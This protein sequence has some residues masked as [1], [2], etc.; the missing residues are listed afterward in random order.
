MIPAAAADALLA[1]MLMDI[2]SSLGRPIRLLLGLPIIVAGFAVA[3]RAMWR[4]DDTR[5]VA[6]L[7]QTGC[8]LFVMAAVGL[9]TPSLHGAL[10]YEAG[11]RVFSLLALVAVGVSA[12]PASTSARG[13]SACW[14]TKARSP[15]PWRP[16]S[17]SWP[18]PTRARP[19]G[20][21]SRRRPGACPEATDSRSSNA[22]TERARFR[23]STQQRYIRTCRSRCWHLRRASC[24]LATTASSQ[25]CPCRSPSR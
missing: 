19:Y 22:C 9:V 11:R 6:W 4:V 18:P 17:P 7:P 16:D 25:R 15:P 5:P 20:V 23:Y 8:V 3:A 21:N 10:W 14:A 24:S 12:T 1:A 13:P 2:G